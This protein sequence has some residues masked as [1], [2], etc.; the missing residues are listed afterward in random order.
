MSTNAGTWFYHPPEN[1]AYN[2]SERING[3]FWGARLIGTYWR[4][5]KDAPPF[6]AEGYHEDGA[7]LRMEWEP[8][9]WLAVRIPPG[10]SADDTVDALSSRV[11]QRSPTLAYTDPDR[12][13]VYE[14][15]TDGGKARWQAI[16]GNPAYAAPR[17]LSYR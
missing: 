1:R 17:R 16:Q 11:L 7:I 9:Q 13:E 8:G 12:N 6:Q 15:H 2:I 3:T 4:C 14:W 10:V 5:V